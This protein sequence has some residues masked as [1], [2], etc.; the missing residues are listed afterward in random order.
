[1]TGPMACAWCQL[2]MRAS[3]L[4]SW[5][6]IIGSSPLPVSNDADEAVAAMVGNVVV[7]TFEVG[8]QLALD[9]APSRL[10]RGRNFFY[11]SARCGS[12]RRSLVPAC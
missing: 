11:M 1:M 5:K 8:D 9:L 12:F 4:R 10:R 6:A 7:R 3:A 2:G